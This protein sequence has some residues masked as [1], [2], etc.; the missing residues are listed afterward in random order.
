MKISK[1]LSLLVALSQ[2]A[3]AGWA[4]AASEVVY[5]GKPGP[6]QGKHVVLLAGDEEL[7]GKIPSHANV[8]Y[9]GA[10][11]PSWF[12]FGKFKPGLRPEDLE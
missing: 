4:K 5:Q 11:K 10:Y 2:I 1:H 6:G 3:L 7:E 8:D 12:G 9:V